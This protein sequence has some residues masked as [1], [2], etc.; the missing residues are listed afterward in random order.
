MSFSSRKHQRQLSQE[1]RYIGTLAVFRRFG[2][3]VQ[4]GRGKVAETGGCPVYFWTC[5][6]MRAFEIFQVCHR[7]AL[8]CLAQ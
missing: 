5:L 7:Y 6:S 4:L 1:R 3:P 2:T 8:L